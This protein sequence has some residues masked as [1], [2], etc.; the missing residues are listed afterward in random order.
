[1]MMTAINNKIED[2]YKKIKILGKGNFGQVFLAEEIDTKRK[3]AIKVVDTTRFKNE[4]QRR[5]AENEK[6]ICKL[7][8]K[9]LKHQHIVNVDQ[10]KVESKCIYFV[11]EYVDGGELYERIKL[12]GKIDELQA[13]I[14]FRELISAVAYIHKVIYTHILRLKCN[15]II[16]KTHITLCIIIA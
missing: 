5:H 11:L 12:E 2:K 9:N 15:K 16:N 8:S 1:M 13:K 7:L 3:V 10:V 4:D 6:E 14:W